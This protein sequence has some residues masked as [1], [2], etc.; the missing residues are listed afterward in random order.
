MR[1]R[2]RDR[3]KRRGRKS[4]RK[5]IRGGGITQRKKHMR[6]VRKKQQNTSERRNRDTEI[7]NRCGVEK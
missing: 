4:Q 6:K 3:E 5:E 2:E 1:Q 7:R